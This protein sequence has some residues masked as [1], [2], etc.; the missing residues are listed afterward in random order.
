MLCV[1]QHVH[2]YIIIMYTESNIFVKA[3]YIIIM[4]F[5]VKSVHVHRYQSVHCILM[6]AY[7]INSYQ[8]MDGIINKQVQRVIWQPVQSDCWQCCVDVN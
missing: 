7:Q 2:K 4:L 1:I 6:W 5:V 3:N 8:F